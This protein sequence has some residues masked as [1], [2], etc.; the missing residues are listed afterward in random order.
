MTSDKVA[1]EE[2]IALLDGENAHMS[3]DDVI[4]DFPMEHINSK[5]INN[6]YSFWHFLEHMRIAQWDILEF[7][8]N[9][10]HV[11]PKYPEGYIGVPRRLPIKRDGKRA[12]P[13]F[14][15]IWRP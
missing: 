10:R 5:P 1:R 15:P 8:R 12:R 6:P 11:S 4:A 13:R 14:G 3:F 2:L 7:I 9:P